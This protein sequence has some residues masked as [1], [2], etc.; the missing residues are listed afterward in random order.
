MGMASYYETCDVKI[1]NEDGLKEFLK[2]AERNDVYQHYAEALK[3]DYKKKIVSFEGFD[4]W[5][6]ISYW[7]PQFLVFLRGLAIFVE[8]SIMLNFETGDE[9]AVIKFEDTEVVLELGAMKYRT[10][11]I[12]ELM[13]DRIT[14][15]KMLRYVEKKGDN[16]LTT[17]MNQLP[18]W[19]Q[20]H[21]LLR[22]I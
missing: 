20:K 7:Y 11:Q 10:V 21:K 9:R 5:K 8:G 18:M 16:N 6:I 17:P 12:E 15:E 14:T 1:E 3:V 22:K 4:G 19:L 13:D 2:A